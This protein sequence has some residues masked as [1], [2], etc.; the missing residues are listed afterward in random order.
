VDGIYSGAALSERSEVRGASGFLEQGGVEGGLR[1][2]AA[3]AKDDVVDRVL[4]P[5][6]SRGGGVTLQPPPVAAVDHGL[7]E[8]ERWAQK[9]IILYS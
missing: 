8:Q 7:S 6:V 5:D 9:H 2:A 1:A 4:P 3:V